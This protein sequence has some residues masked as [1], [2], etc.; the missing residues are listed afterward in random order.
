MRALIPWSRSVWCFLA[1]EWPFLLGEPRRLIDVLKSRR[2]DDIDAVCDVNP[3]PGYRFLQL[4]KSVVDSV[5]VQ[6]TKHCP[7]SPMGTKRYTMT[8]HKVWQSWS[9]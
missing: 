7:A 1:G 4:R 9:I 6:H 5:N 3:K 8:C 2:P